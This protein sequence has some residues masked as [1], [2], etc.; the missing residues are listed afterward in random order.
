MSSEYTSNL[1]LSI[2]SYKESSVDR[3][4]I[5]YIIQVQKSSDTWNLEKRFSEFSDLHKNLSKLFKTLPSF[6]SKTITKQTDMH[7]LHTRQIAL[8]AYLK[9]CIEKLEIF[10]SEPLKKFLQLDTFSPETSVSAPRLL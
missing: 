3:N 10:S 1:K 2:P 5:Y 8:E 7:F 9:A 4:V 6:P